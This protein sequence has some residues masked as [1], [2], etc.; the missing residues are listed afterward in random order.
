MF[1]SGRL[2]II[3][4]RDVL[5]LYFLICLSLCNELVLAQVRNKNTIFDLYYLC[6]WTFCFRAEACLL[7][8][9]CI[10]QLKK[11]VFVFVTFG[12]WG[13]KSGWFCNDLILGV[14]PLEVLFFS[15]GVEIYFLKH[16]IEF[17]QLFI[18]SLLQCRISWKNSKLNMYVKEEKWKF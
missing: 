16:D 9:C 1:W 17:I 5:I 3:M 2:L 7:A 6:P 15:F 8:C 11:I 18:I 4:Y 12:V 10:A 14:L 13:N